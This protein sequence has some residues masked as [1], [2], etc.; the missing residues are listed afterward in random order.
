MYV[1]TIF[2]CNL[3]AKIAI[4]HDK[5]SKLRFFA[6]KDRFRDFL[7]EKANLAIF[8]GKSQILPYRDDGD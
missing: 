8:R 5:K 2:H 4:Y 3:K 6:E 7:R 1:N